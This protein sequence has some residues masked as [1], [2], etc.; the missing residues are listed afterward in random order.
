MVF[1]QRQQGAESIWRSDDVFD[2]LQFGHVVACLVG[3]G[4]IQVAHRQP[5]LLVF[6]DGAAD[7]AFAPVVGCQCQVPVAKTAMQF[8]KVI[9][10]RAGRGQHIAPVVAECILLELKIFAGG[11]HELPQAGRFC[12][13][14][15]LRVERALDERQQRQF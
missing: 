13:G 6:G 5:V 9:Q 3:H 10:R 8:F 7:A 2:R 14:N 11:R 15:A 12:A 4:Q 1:D